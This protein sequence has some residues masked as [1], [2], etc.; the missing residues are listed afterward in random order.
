[1]IGNLNELLAEAVAKEPET[2]EY[3]QIHFVVASG[4]AVIRKVECG[5]S[6]TVSFPTKESAIKAAIEIA[7]PYWRETKVGKI[8]GCELD[9][10][11]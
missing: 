1:M 8:V 2:G 11:W 3:Y 9:L 7:V 10:S 6:E 4:A 5:Q